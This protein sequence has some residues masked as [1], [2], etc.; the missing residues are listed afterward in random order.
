MRLAT[1]SVA[2]LAVTLLVFAIAGGG[3]A[4]T[5]PPATSITFA[6]PSDGAT[7]AG[8]RVAVAVNVSGLMLVPAGS[9]QKVGTGHAHVLIDSSAPSPRT[10]L[11]TDDPRIVHFGKPP[12][13]SRS[14]PLDNGTHTLTAVLGDSEHLVVGGQRVQT[15]HITVADGFRGKGQLSPG[16]SNLATGTSEV[17]LTF[18]TD[19]GN[20]QGTISANCGFA[21]NSG[22]CQWVDALF[23]RIDGLYDAPSQHLTGRTSGISQRRLRSGSRKTCGP[24]TQSSV[25][26]SNMQA[27]MNGDTVTGTVSNAHFELA[28]DDSVDLAA[29]P[30][31]IV[32]PVAA[33]NKVGTNKLIALAAF[34]V[35]AALLVYAVLAA[36]RAR[37]NQPE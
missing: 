8:P 17:R 10:F 16:C 2:V 24:D 15:I 32:A 19:G 31:P 23:D 26:P 27:D 1:R 12:F 30:D 28:S 33:S 20:V 25:S 35:A 34:A 3:V 18:P 14:I 21:T 5:A 11:S 9:F 6:T 22:A 36:L 7:V 37:Q 13:T 4:A 29:A